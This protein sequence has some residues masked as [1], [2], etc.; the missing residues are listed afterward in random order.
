MHRPPSD[1]A[2]DDASGAGLD[3]DPEG[4]RV[5]GRHRPSSLPTDVAE[6]PAPSTRVRVLIV[7][8]DA[9]A[10]RAATQVLRRMGGHRVTTFTDPEM[11]L[12]YLDVTGADILLADHDVPGMRGS[13]LVRQARR[14]IPGLPAILTAATPSVEMAVEAVRLRVDDLLIKPLVAA[15]LLDKVADAVA[16]AGSSGRERVLAV[17]AHPDDVEIGVGGTLLSHRAS[18]D[19][20]TILTLSGGARGG[21]KA[22][23]RREAEAAAAVIG[24][25]LLME[26]LEDT[27][28][29]ESDPTVAI[30]ERVITEVRPTIIYTHSINDVHQDHRNTHSAA[31]VAS[32]SLPYVLCFQSPSATIAFRPSRFVS[33]EHTLE[34][35]LE[36]IRAFDS[37]ASTREYLDEELLRATARYWAR[38]GGGTAVE[39]FEVVRDRR[40]PSP[41]SL[42]SSAPKV[43]HGDTRFVVSG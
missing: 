14:R 5:A 34:G 31:M 28:I 19:Q 3:V 16:R 27:H 26:D 35:K 2:P 13:E 43:T 7:D 24:A 30:I 15:E 39:A 29:R 21:N 25:R 10:A 8:G 33:I 11:A 22:S 38:F 18:G 1:E 42:A 40:R 9:A 4:P 17:G 41:T 20:V 32:R 6:G 36:A 12:R 23:R 37:Q